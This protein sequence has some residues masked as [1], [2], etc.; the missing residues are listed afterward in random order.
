MAGTK[1]KRQKINT[2]ISIAPLGSDSF[3]LAPDTDAGKDDEERELESVLF[4][5]PFVSSAADH[6]N[7]SRVDMI[8]GGKE[9]LGSGSGFDR[10]VDEDV[11]SS[12]AHRIHAML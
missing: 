1:R 4:G 7:D 10:V 12:M 11:S 3:V 9:Q 8:D 6:K 2:S 5:K